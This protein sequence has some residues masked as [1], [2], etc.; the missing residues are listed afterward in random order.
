MALLLNENDLRPLFDEPS[1]MDGLLEMITE[2]FRSQQEGD[3]VNHPD[4]RLSLKD[5]KRNFRILS[6]TAP[7]AGVG[8]RL[9]PLFSGAKDANFILLFDNDQGH[10]LALVPGG[11]LNVWRTGAPAGVAC[12]HLTPGNGK[13]LGLLGSGRQA[14]GQ[15]LAIRRSLPSLQRV[16]VYECP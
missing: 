10:F 14:K 13:E 8:V 12:Q 5:R 6:A 1:S 3:G 15:L 2:A 4:L 16:R 9:F 7:E 11:E